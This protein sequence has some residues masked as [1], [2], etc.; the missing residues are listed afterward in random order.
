MDPLA[1]AMLVGWAVVA[2]WDEAAGQARVEVGQARDRVHT[3]I[4]RQREAAPQWMAQSRAAGPKRGRWWGWLGLTATRVG[5]RIGWRTTRKSTRAVGYLLAALGRIAAAGARGARREWA[6]RKDQIK[7]NRLRGRESHSHQGHEPKPNPTPNGDDQVV[8]AEVVDDPPEAADRAESS[9]DVVDAE[10]VPP[11]ALP[12]PQGG[13]TMGVP[14][15]TGSVDTE[16]MTLGQLRQYM[17]GA[18]TRAQ[19]EVAGLDNIMAN[20]TSVHID[21]GTLTEMSTLQDQYHSVLTAVC[22]AAQ[23]V[24]RQHN[25]VG[26]AVQEVGG[27]DKVANKQFYGEV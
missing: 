13:H 3:Y 4:H 2:G 27:P 1:I 11:P 23:H 16:A 22:R 21:S 10:V 26:E 18:A 9:Q 25:S 24:E 12:Q 17:R 14:V 5:W 6:H 19:R 15:A 20:L 8:D 7:A